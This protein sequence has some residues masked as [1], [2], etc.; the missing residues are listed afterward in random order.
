MAHHLA[1]ATSNGRIISAMTTIVPSSWVAPLDQWEAWMRAAARPTTTIYL[2]HYQLRR[3]A[4]ELGVADPWAVT[5]DDLV[6][7]L[8]GHGW[9]P[10]TI[11]SYRAALK[12]FYSWAHVTGQI[13][14]DPAGLLPAVATPKRK[15]RPTPE[16]ALEAAL[17][18]ASARIRLMVLLAAREGLRR[19]EIAQVHTRDLEQDLVD[20]WYLRVHGK[21]AKERI[22]PLCDEVR[23]L[24]RSAPEGYVFPGRIDGHLSPRYVGKLVSGVFDV[25]WTT[26]TLRH[27]FATI[28]HDGSHDLAAV[29]TPARA[30]PAGDDDGLH[31]DPQRVTACCDAVG[32]LK[33]RTHHDRR[34][35][36][37]CRLDP[38]R[39]VG[40][41][42]QRPPHRGSG[43]ALQRR[44]HR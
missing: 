12:T 24:L 29:Q 40:V 8:G 38:A 37:H 18:E 36:H 25:G 22:L 11:R 34:R 15:A 35:L 9:A 43:A 14:A 28:C 6:A 26:H 30:L 4:R 13:L 10:E 41:A 32:S 16:S 27:R 7:W 20:G 5:T 1:L 31:P 33:W 2:R 39:A 3:L 17:Q 42:D 23:V 21:G 44:P 19:G